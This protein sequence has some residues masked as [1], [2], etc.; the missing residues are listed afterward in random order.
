MATKNYRQCGLA[1]GNQRS[2]GWIEERGAKLGAKVEIEELGGMW[3][4]IGVGDTVLSRE[5]MLAKQKA[6]RNAFGSILPKKEADGTA[7]ESAR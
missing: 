7:T 5:E 2:Q 4:V 3:E 1:Q 6:N